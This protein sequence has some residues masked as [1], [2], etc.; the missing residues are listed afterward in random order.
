MSES[1]ESRR[2]ALKHLVVLGGAALAC[3]AVAPSLVFVAQ[4]GGEGGGA[5]GAAGGPR[6]VRTVKLESLRDGAPKR[7]AIV[8]DD[9]DAWAVSR[10]VTLGAVWLVRKGDEVVAF[11]A[12]CPHLGCSVSATADGFAC[13]CHESVFAHDGA[14]VSGPSPRG[15]DPM[16]TR[17]ADGFVE[18]GFSRFKLGTPSREAIG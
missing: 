12:V 13:P 4:S 9:R 3:A 6:W 2:G 5:G 7:V 16:T 1:D 17:I 11:S 15:L 8:G 10:D 18:V 14:M